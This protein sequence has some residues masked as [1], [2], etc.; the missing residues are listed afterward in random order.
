MQKRHRQ[1]QRML[2]YGLDRALVPEEEQRQDEAGAACLSDPGA[3]IPPP[4]AATSPRGAATSPRHRTS[5]RNTTAP[6]ESPNTGSRATKKR[7]IHRTGR[8]T[9]PGRGRRCPVAGAGAGRL[10]GTRTT[11]SPNTFLNGTVRAGSRSATAVTAYHRRKEDGQERRE[12]HIMIIT[13]YSNLV[14]KNKKARV[15]LATALLGRIGSDR[16]RGVSDRIKIGWSK[17]CLSA[18][19]RGEHTAISS[20]Q[21][22]REGTARAK[23]EMLVSAAMALA[24]E[25]H[26]TPKCSRSS[27]GKP[28]AAGTKSDQKTQSSKHFHTVGSDHPTLR[29]KRRFRMV[30]R[31]GWPTLGVE[32][33]WVS[34]AQPT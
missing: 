8:G 15:G 20:V 11:V 1:R 13:V 19:K 12:R 10:T 31:I 23:R 22:R 27:K 4:G 25:S 9:A 30:D 21:Q 17:G 29:P 14:L 28:A 34:L 26:R 24:L 33:H 5:E 6:G 32:T 3:R 2:S 16:K 18:E 7:G